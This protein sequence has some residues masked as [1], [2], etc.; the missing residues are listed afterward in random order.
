MIEVYFSN[1]YFIKYFYLINKVIKLKEK[2]ENL[3]LT[4]KVNI[5]QLYK[6]I[7]IDN[8]FIIIWDIIL[9]STYIYQIFFIPFQIS[10]N[11]TNINDF[12]FSYL[13]STLIFSFNILFDFT[14]GYYKKGVYITNKKKIAKHFLKTNLIPDVMFI[15]LYYLS[16]IYS[17]ILALLILIKILY[18]GDLFQRLSDRLLKFRMKFKF[19]FDLGSILIQVLLL[20]HFCACIW[21]FQASGENNWLIKANLNDSHWL[22]Q[23]IAS[24]YFSIVTIVTVGYGD[25]TPNNRQ[26]QILS[27]FLIAIG[28]GNFGY[29]I[30]SIHNVFIELNKNESDFK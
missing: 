26:E 9:L 16:N 21:I 24:F 5:I 6:S 18:T 19:F 1:L 12:S 29:S 3:V 10:F 4:T 11:W 8:N 30:G 20:T 2:I 25:I 23:Y 15:F 22:D 28:C 7:K 14:R 17:K 13:I 27:I